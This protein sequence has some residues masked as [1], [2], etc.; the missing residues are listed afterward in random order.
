MN[1]KGA[2]FIGALVILVLVLFVVVIQYERYECTKNIHCGETSYCGVDHKCHEFP[3]KSVQSYTKAAAMF[4]LI[5]GIAIMVAA[6]IL[7][8]KKKPQQ[9]YYQPETA[10]PKEFQES[11]MFKKD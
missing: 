3:A 10:G 6:L 2:F 1:K 7:K 11:Q 9:T 5:V 4:G 8:Q